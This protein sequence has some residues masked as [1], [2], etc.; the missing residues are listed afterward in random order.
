MFTEPS[1]LLKPDPNFSNDTE[2]APKR[3]EIVMGN[4]L[5]CTTVHWHSMMLK[6]KRTLG[7]NKQEI[8]EL[9]MHDHEKRRVRSNN[10]V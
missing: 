4:Q 9:Y 2:N 1:S 5:T 10:L 7:R 8:L 6:R 3:A